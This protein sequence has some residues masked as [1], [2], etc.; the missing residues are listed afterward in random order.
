MTENETLLKAVRR[1]LGWITLT[2]ILVQAVRP[3]TMLV[4][5]RMLVPGDYG[6]MAVAGVVIELLRLV[7]DFGAG[8]AYIQHRGDADE[9]LNVVFWFQ[10]LVGGVLTLAV[11]LTAAPLAVFLGK[12]EIGPVL[13]FLSFSFLLYPF[14]DA[15]LNRMLRQMD[16]KASFYRQVIP[17]VISIPLSIVLAWMGMGVWALAIS[18]VASIAATGVLVMCLARWWPARPRWNKKLVG[19]ILHFGG[20]VSLQNLLVWF[21]NSIDQ[22]FLAKFQSSY[23]IGLFR[24]GSLVGGFGWTLVAGPFAGVLLPWFS[25]MER[26]EDVQTTYLSCLRMLAL[27]SVPVNVFLLGVAAPHIGVLLSRQ[28]A[29]AAA[30]AVAFGLLNLISCL[31]SMNGEVLKAIGRPGLATR[32]GVIRVAMAPL[33]FYFAARAGIYHLALAEM[34]LAYVTAFAFLPF[35]A[36][37]LGLRWQALA[38]ACVPGFRIALPAAAVAAAGRLAFVWCEPGWLTFFISAGL[39]AGVTGLAFHYFEPQAVARIR[40]MVGRRLF[41]ARPGGPDEC[42]AV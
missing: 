1:G 31:V 29:D 25:R 10:L 8:Q 19:A 41:P 11:C 12:P 21:G 18:S 40:Q 28:W 6:I 17:A 42:A 13:Q 16:F 24:T 5:A 34:A 26:R 27:V 30:V 14:G 33:A 22:A 32:L 15:P 2:N 9:M 7:K 36:R 20:H 39:S 37:A 38:A 4:L 23:N 35:V 3:V